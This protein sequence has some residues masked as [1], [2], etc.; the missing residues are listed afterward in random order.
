MA[1]T[2]VPQRSQKK[3]ICARFNM[4][5]ADIRTQH[6]EGDKRREEKRRGKK[7]Q[8]RSAEFYFQTNQL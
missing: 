1:K 6:G 5:L 2:A 4:L 8:L 3:N 7:V